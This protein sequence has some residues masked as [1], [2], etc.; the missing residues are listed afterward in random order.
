MQ[1]SRIQNRKFKR[2]LKSIFNY[3]KLRTINFNSSKKVALIWTITVFISLFLKWTNSSDSNLIFNWLSGINIWTWTIII[4]LSI[5]LI[6]LLF[7]NNKKE[8]IKQTSNLMIKDYKI[9]NIIWI[10]LLILS[11]NSIYIIKSLYIFSNDI[12]YWNWI[13]FTIIWSLFIIYSSFML[14]KENKKE[15]NLYLN[16]SEE[17]IEKVNKKNNMKLPF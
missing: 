17:D 1:N 10:I 13:I 9:I 3:F 5:F 8:K 14:K 16:D 11:I 6:F 4:L 7:S 15:N 2:H 12:D